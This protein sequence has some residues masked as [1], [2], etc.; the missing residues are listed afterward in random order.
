MKKYLANS[1]LGEI[2]PV[3]ALRETESSVF[4]AT[5]WAPERGERRDKISETRGYFDTW[6]E[7]R[8]FLI[9]I[10]EQKIA[11]LTRELARRQENV[12]KIEEMTE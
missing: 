9:E 12:R 8:R 1:T 5:E 2:K 10:E 3:E 11:T 4:I 7:A 6:I